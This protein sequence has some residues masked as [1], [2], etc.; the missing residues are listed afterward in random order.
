MYHILHTVLGDKNRLNSRISE[1][2]DITNKNMNTYFIILII[3]L[4]LARIKL[5]NNLTS[6]S[7]ENFWLSLP[8]SLSMCS[9][10]CEMGMGGWEIIPGVWKLSLRIFT[11]S[12]GAAGM[13]PTLPPPPPIPPPTWLP[14][15]SAIKGFVTWAWS[16]DLGCLRRLQ[17]E[18]MCVKVLPMSWFVKYYF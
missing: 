14:P 13:T 17:R 15:W 12:E 2:S 5:T 9:A 6:Y 3:P 8:L 4:L 1:I 11:G 7:C 10:S 16:R 18:V